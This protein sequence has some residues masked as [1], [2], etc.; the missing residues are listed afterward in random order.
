MQVDRGD[1]AILLGAHAHVEHHLMTRVRSSQR[2][3]ARVDDLGGA[4]GALRHERGED[5]AASRLLG[6]EATAD[7]WLDDAHLRLRNLECSGD[8]A[9][10]MERHLRGTRHRNATER[11][12]GRECAEGLHHRLGGGLRLVRAIDHDVGFGKGGIEVAHRVLAMGHEVPRAVAA[13]S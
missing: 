10:D 9:A 7:A 4:A 2:L 1:G 12:D 8:L 11:V 13:R 6:A 5:L 3:L